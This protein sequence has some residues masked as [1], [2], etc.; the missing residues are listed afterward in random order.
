MEW[1]RW[2]A[3]IQKWLQAHEALWG[4]LGLL[5]VISLIGTMIAVLL[6]LILLPQHYLLQNNIQ[7]R[8]LPRPLRI[9]YLVA[10]NA[11][12]IFF[13]LAGSVMLLLPGQGLITLFLGIVLVDLPGKRRFIR[14]LARQQK[15]LHYINRLRAKANRPPLETQD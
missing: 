4:W 7:N 10:K 14:R 6:I 12:G 11:L 3:P 13:I 15:I 1:N 8:R 5:S 2:G 9:P